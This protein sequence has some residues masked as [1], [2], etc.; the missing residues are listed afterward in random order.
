VQ[1]MSVRRQGLETGCHYFAG[2][3]SL[4]FHPQN[5]YVPTFRADVRYFE[6][7][8]II[9]SVNVLVIKYYILV[10]VSVTNCVKNCR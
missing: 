1:A 2:A 3:L 9:V 4:V 5:P 10:L 6:V 8:S 7:I